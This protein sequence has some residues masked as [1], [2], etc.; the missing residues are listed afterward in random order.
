MCLHKI[1]LVDKGELPEDTMLPRAWDFDFFFLILLWLLFFCVFLR[2]STAK[3][4]NLM[5]PCAELMNWI[6]CYLLHF[7]I[8]KVINE[9]GGNMVL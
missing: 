4:A 7:Y 6:V 8:Q 9:W 1:T 5:L 2:D 3:K